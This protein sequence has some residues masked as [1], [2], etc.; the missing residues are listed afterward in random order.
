MS[1]NN[2]EDQQF[3]SEKASDDVSSEVDITVSKKRKKFDTNG[4]ETESDPS[5]VSKKSKR[6][7]EKSTK[8]KEK[9]TKNNEKSTKNEAEEDFMRIGEVKPKVLPKVSNVL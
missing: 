1:D 8:N 7:N 4:N 2:D 3:Q 5:R 6:N 9:S